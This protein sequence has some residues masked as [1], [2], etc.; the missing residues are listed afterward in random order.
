MWVLSAAEG[1]HCS[2]VS[3]QQLFLRVFTDHLENL[4]VDGRLIF[5]PF[6]T[7][8]VLLKVQ[9]KNYCKVPKFSDARRLCC[10]LPKIQTKRPN[11]RVFLLND[12]NGIENS[13]DP[14]QTAPR[15]EVCNFRFR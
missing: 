12:A 13:K 14:D 4:F 11:I 5:F 3:E 2:Q 9:N 1:E 7:H 8:C 6:F 10:N 15:L